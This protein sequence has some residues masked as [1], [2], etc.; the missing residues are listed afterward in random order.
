MSDGAPPADWVQVSVGDLAEIRHGF[1]FKGEYFRD[2]APGDLLLTPANFKP[3]GGFNDQKF[4]YYVGDDVPAAFVLSEGDLLV[5]MTDLS[6]EAA[7]L[8][9][10]AFVPE[11]GGRRLL[12]NQ[13]LGKVVVRPDVDC[14]PRFLFYVLCSP[15]YRHHV[16]ARATGTTVRHTSPRQI[17]SFCFRLPPPDE[18]QRIAGVLGALDTKLGANRRVASAA[19]GFLTRLFHA[20]VL[21]QEWPP[22]ALS[23]QLEVVMGQ[24]PPGSSY[25]ADAAGP[26]LVQGMGAFGE[27]F[28]ATD[29]RTSA[30]TRTARRGDVLMTVR[31]PVGEVNVADDEYCVGRGVAVLRGPY[32]AYAEQLVRSLSDK[33]RST[34]AGTIF[35]AVN[36]NQVKEMLAP[37]PPAEVAAAFEH[38]ASPLYRL[39]QVMN[40]ENKVLEQI[41]AALVPKL[42]SGEMRVPDGY[43]VAT[44]QSD[45]VAAA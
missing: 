19:E 38:A 42:V 3:G 18:Q 7:T 31:A 6:K 33:W 11:E 10:P 27:R 34:E 2:E 24:S 9:Y 25:A 35:P 16:L 26:L 12:H 23:G 8:G 30:P 4:K 45:E 14:D 21:E 29:V 20:Q 44:P 17:A 37:C 39:L 40:Y 41:R 28:P 15:L 1:A 5:S 22:G 36:V 13:R 32:P 43:L